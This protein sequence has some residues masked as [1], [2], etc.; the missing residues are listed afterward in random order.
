[1]GPTQAP[2]DLHELLDRDFDWDFKNFQSSQ[3]EETGKILQQAR[4]AVR[5]RTLS[6]DLF[7]SMFL[8]LIFP[9]LYSV[10]DCIVISCNSPPNPYG[11]H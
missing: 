3:F 4:M 11:N 7:G 6:G 1:M 10:D 8:V 5:V 9:F 2:P